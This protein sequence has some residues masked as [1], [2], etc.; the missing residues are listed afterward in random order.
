MRVISFDGR[1]GKTAEVLTAKNGRKYLRMSV[2]NNMFTSNEE[3]T[4]WF[5]VTC[6]DEFIVDKRAKYL[7]KGTYVIVTGSIIT[8]VKPKNGKI[9]VNHYV[10]A[11][12]IDTPR[13]GKNQDE[14]AQSYQDESSEPE[15]SVYTANT[16]TQRT[17]QEAPVAEPTMSVPSYQPSAPSYEDMNYDNNDDLPF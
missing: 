10:T 8:E 5:E 4:D 17:Y 2:A 13:F 14:G 16:A 11:T 6:Y 7:T 15:V 1:I 12:S 3:R 9:W